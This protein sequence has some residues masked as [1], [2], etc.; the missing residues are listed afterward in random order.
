MHT[1]NTI[2][3][4]DPAKTWSDTFHLLSIYHSMQNVAISHGFYFWGRNER[5]FPQFRK[6]S[7]SWLT[8]NPNVVGQVTQH[9][10][11][12]GSNSIGNV[13]HNERECTFVT[14]ISTQWDRCVCVCATNL[15]IGLC[16]PRLSNFIKGRYL[17][18]LLLLL[19]LYVLAKR[20]RAL[21]SKIK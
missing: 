3:Y 19:S 17:V 6:V 4:A 8:P 10:V 12:R 9:P 18:I 20:Q 13:H 15:F 21:V 7:G 14:K 2:K 16:K 1:L 5:F 11:T